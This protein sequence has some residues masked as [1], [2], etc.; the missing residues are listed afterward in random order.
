MI[1]YLRFANCTQ[2][3]TI[4]KYGMDVTFVPASFKWAR[5]Y[6]AERKSYT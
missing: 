5:T 1:E 2:E 4:E 3:L 6:N